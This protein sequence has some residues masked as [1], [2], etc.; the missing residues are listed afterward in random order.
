M[1]VRY[2]LAQHVFVSVIR[3]FYVL[4]DTTTDEHLLLSALDAEPLASRIAGWPL[5]ATSRSMT[6]ASLGLASEILL[7][8]MESRGVLVRDQS[9]GK[10][11]TPILVRRATTQLGQ[12][13]E[14]SSADVDLKDILRF[15]RCTFIAALLLR[16]RS[17][18]GVRAYR[19][20]KTTSGS[21]LGINTQGIASPEAVRLQLKKFKTLAPFLTA[22]GRRSLLEPIVLAEFL[23]IAGIPAQVVLGVEVT[24]FTVTA[25]VQHADYLLS[26]TPEAI[27]S[28]APILSI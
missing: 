26:G 17:V 8:Q 15:S 1:P 5:A 20:S 3:E 23:R 2:W 13:Y 24:P 11:A 21:P 19:L 7:E 14:E 6:D 9:L 27:H 28:F 25:W 4:F 22:Q 16:F 10:P 18:A 12:D